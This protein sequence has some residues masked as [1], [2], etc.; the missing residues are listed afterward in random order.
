MMLL[1][2]LLRTA[3][4]VHPEPSWWD[5]ISRV[6]YCARALLVPRLTREWFDILGAPKLAVIVQNHPHIFSKLQRSYLDRSPGPWSRLQALKNHYRFVTLRLSDESV[7]GVYGSSGLVLTRIPLAESGSV[8]LRLSYYDSLSKE[9]EMC[10]A[11]HDGDT[12]G[13]LAALSFCVTQYEPGP[14]EV[15]VGGLQGFTSAIQRERI[16]TITRALHGLRPKAL[17]LYALQQL[18]AVWQLDS[19]RA[20]SDS[21]HVYRHYRKRK[22]VAMSYDGFWVESGGQLG[23]DGLFTLPTAF[24]PRDL[25]ELKP[26]KRQMY[27]RRYIMLQELAKQIRDS[28]ARHSLPAN[29]SSPPCS[30]RRFSTRGFGWAT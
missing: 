4:Q 12:G 2:Q 7:V 20:V 13:M 6:K 14:T 19:I 11:V 29:V 15:F 1:F 24:A 28:L 23:A 10:V 5:W 27:R 26:S 21:Q 16:I 30:A 8:E 18:A 22:K 25:S 17:L 9:G 3:R